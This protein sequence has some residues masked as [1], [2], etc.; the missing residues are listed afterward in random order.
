V[1]V[2]IL[3]WSLLDSETT[4]DELRE[5]LPSLPYP[6]E[7]IWNESGERFGIIAFGDDLPEAVGWARDLIGDD[8]DVYDEF[9]TVTV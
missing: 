3:I 4:I 9:D 2:R 1:V 6:G 7:W 8:A 5:G